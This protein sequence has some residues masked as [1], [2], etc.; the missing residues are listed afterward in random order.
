MGRAT[1]NR[2]QR[3]TAIFRR[4]TYL[5]LRDFEPTDAML[6]YGGWLS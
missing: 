2:D 3:A 6:N 5:Q 4:K 1:L